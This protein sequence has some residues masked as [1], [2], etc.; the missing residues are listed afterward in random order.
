MQNY[1]KRGKLKEK[2]TPYHRNRGKKNGLKEIY[3]RKTER[4]YIV[5]ARKSED[6]SIHCFAKS[7]VEEICYEVQTKGKESPYPYPLISIQQ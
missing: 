2:Q 4:D 5:K 1:I 7:K 3:Q 6:L